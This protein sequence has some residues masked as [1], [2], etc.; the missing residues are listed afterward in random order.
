MP[1]PT[2]RYYS[3]TAVA[4]TLS[5]SIS[6]S[7]TS[8]SVGAVTGWP[9][10]YPFTLIIGE[11]TASEELV[12]VSNVSGTTVTVSARGVG[13]TTAQAHA[14]GSTVAHGV[15]A[16]DFED[17]S[18]HYAA[19]TAVHGVTGSVV[20]TTDTQTLTGKSIDGDSNTVTDL[21]YSA[22]KQ[23][24]WTAWTPTWANMT[25]GNATV[26]ARYAR[27]GNIVNWRIELVT[28]TTTSYTATAGTFTLPITAASAGQ[29]LGSWGG[30]A[31]SVWVPHTTTVGT[32][33]LY[34]GTAVLDS[35]SAPGTAT[36]FTFSGTYEAA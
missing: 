7:A 2:R 11:D 28:G 35:S 32:P 20:G 19:S 29:G 6:D 30:V 10:S 36:A 33:Y 17:G 4:T 14:A 26:T 3:S 34:N 16:Q 23:A 27:V 9:S 12:T 24:A 22:V 5:G 8:W 21:A 1:S 13:G 18:A 31:T 25:I 15:Y